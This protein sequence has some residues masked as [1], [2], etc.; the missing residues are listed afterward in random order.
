LVFGGAVGEVAV[1][2]VLDYLLG[3]ESASAFDTRAVG[4]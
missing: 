3:D 2:G 4:V 1:D